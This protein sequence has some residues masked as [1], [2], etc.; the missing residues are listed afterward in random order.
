MSLYK[1]DEVI[2]DL[3]A[4]MVRDYKQQKVTEEKSEFISF[5][6]SR[7]K[8]KDMQDNFIDSRVPKY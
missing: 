5:G 6:T 3:I 2:P 4:L 7:C 1:Y 8:L